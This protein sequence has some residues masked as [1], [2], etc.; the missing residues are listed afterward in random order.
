MKIPLSWLKDYV[1]IT[2]DLEELAK[3]LTM[4]G[5]EVDEIQLVGLP[6]PA[7]AQH[8][9][10]YSG[11]SWDREKIVVAEITEV[12]PHPNADRLVLCK[13]NDGTQEHLVLT[14]APNL[15]DY[16]NKGPLSPALKV[17]YAKEGAEIYD[18]HQPGLVL[19]TLK[20]AKIRGV[21]SYSMVC[22]EKELGI[23]EEHEGIILFDADAPTGTPLVDYIGDAVFELSILPNMIRN[24]CVIGVARELAAA[25]GQK[26][27]KPVVSVN[28]TGPEISGKINIDIKVPE[29]N[30]RF[31]VGLI[32]N[33]EIKPSPFVIQTRLK[34]AGMRP[35]NNIVDATNYMMLE[36][37]QP[38][39]AFDYDELV[40]RANGKTPTIIT[41]QAAKGEI[42]TT[43]DR[44]EHKLDDFTVLVCDTR[45]A[46]SIAG[47]MGG[48]E[49]E[50]SANTKNVLL[51]GASWNFINIRKTVASQKINSEAGYR[52]SRGIHPDIA[53][54][55]VVRSL[56]LMQQ[57]SGGLVSSGLVDAYPLKAQ[58][59]QVTITESDVVRLLGIE[60][61]AREIAQYLEKLEFKCTVQDKMVK[62][63]APDFRLDIGDGV[64]GKADVL[65]E[66]A[67]LYGY[68]R[69]PETRL[70]DVMPAQ[71]G[72]PTLEF[73]EKLRD[74]MANLGLQEVVS[75]R[76]TTPERESKLNPEPVE[77]FPEY[78][79]LQNPI[80]PERRVMRRSILASVLD[81]VE[82]NSR[83][84]DRLLMFE[85]GHIYIPASG[86]TL[87][88][89]LPHLGIV[90][91]GLRSAPAWDVKS[92]AM[93]D[94][95]DLK[96]ILD[97]LFTAFQLPEISYEV[98][99]NAAFHPGKQA[100]VLS[101]GVKI[102]DFG[103]LHPLV[104]ASYDTTYEDI[105]AADVDV[106]ALFD[107]SQKVS[108]L[109]PVPA[110]PPILED[111]AIVVDEDLSAGV[112]E[113][114]IRQTGGKLLTGVRLFDIFRGA[115][116]GENK[117]SMAYNLTYQA[118]DRTLTDKDATQIRNKIIRRLEQEL[119]AKLRS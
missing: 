57:W 74:V 43:L 21:D 30:P 2:L 53:K 49:T 62:V 42:L 110:F 72:N 95:Y 51:E 104:Q 59:V 89:E 40:K 105:L 5:L 79:T 12:L 68:E 98:G 87:P 69:I 86:Q 41:R 99:E 16:K 56:E 65:E 107:C 76:L 81:N 117:K 7:G 50:V 13:L 27:K 9:F 47:V 63:T 39:H 67:R 92:P 37:G 71:Y 61:S 48:L 20:R 44:V 8:E 93:L 58:P 24:A 80:T 52:F 66:I 33:V 26:L 55:G 38:L 34:L 32:E 91:A 3:T 102:C 83:V 85:I 111:I 82:K 29:L 108:Q 113:Q 4:A 36:E 1:D 35:I 14:G 94:F 114:L 109:I 77:Q 54:T 103:A 118:A 25:T 23:S 15:F 88:D 90:L 84:A 17:A 96:G 100:R 78:V 19:T 18:G 11:F 28:T 60:L 97:A 22:S 101:G 119:G 64:T 45:A 106:T 46:L 31:V 112:I 73:E 10:K 115:Q 6:M 70:A 116:I 75:Y